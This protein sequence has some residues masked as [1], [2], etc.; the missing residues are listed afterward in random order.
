[1]TKN[2][3]AKNL[4]KYN[5]KKVIPDKRKTKYEK[6]LDRMMKDAASIQEEY[7]KQYER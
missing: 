5:K 3:I 7:K 6:V 1:M 2:P 4:N